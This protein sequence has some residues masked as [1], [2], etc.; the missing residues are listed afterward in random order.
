VIAGLVLVLVPG[1]EAYRGIG[2]NLLVFFGTLYA[3]RGAGV[4]A[5]FVTPGRTL[6]GVLLAVALV[7]L[8]RD[9]AAVALGLVGIGDTWADWRRRAARTA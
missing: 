9:G 5:W 4:L 1:A 3:L 7:L 2:S 6:V 8:L